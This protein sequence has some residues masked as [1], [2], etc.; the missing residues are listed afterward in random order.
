MKMYSYIKKEEVIPKE[1]SVQVKN[2][3]N[4]LF[5]KNISIILHIQ[6]KINRRSNTYEQKEKV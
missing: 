3:F 1:M 4:N 2:L 5:S 6:F